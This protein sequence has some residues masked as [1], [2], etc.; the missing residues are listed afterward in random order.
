MTKNRFKVSPIKHFTPI[1][2]T[3]VRE[4]S[5]APQGKPYDNGMNLIENI[6]RTMKGSE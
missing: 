6:S 4:M 3:G 1:R 5:L 2:L